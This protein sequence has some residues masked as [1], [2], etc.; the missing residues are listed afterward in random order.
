MLPTTCIHVHLVQQQCE[1]TSAIPSENGSC[2]GIQPMTLSLALRRRKLLRIHYQP[3]RPRNAG[4]PRALRERRRGALQGNRHAPLEK[5]IRASTVAALVPRTASYCASTR[6]CTAVLASEVRKG[7]SYRHRR[8]RRASTRCKG[9]QQLRARQ[10]P[11]LDSNFR[12]VVVRKPSWEYTAQNRAPCVTTLT[13]PTHRCGAAPHA[14]PACHP[15]VTSTAHRPCE[16]EVQR[17]NHEYYAKLE[18][19]G[20][21]GTDPNPTAQEARSAQVDS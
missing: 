18:R 20:R 11:Q 7:S 4:P 2:L 1:I 13:S 14:L 17:W 16:A 9:A 10:Q 5:R 19:D 12:K 6:P 8:F 21:P 3:R 15:P